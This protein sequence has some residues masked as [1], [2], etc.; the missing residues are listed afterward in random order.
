MSLSKL[1]LVMIF[2]IVVVD[3]GRAAV[4]TFS[5]SKAITE[6]SDIN[7]S[8]TLIAA[9][10][11]GGTDVSST[12]VNGVTFSPFALTGNPTTVGD[13]E[14]SET[15]TAAGLNAANVFGSSS[16]P[17]SVLSASYRSLL[18]TAIYSGIE[19]AMVLEFNNLTIGQSYLI[20]LCSNFSNTSFASS[21]GAKTIQGG[22]GNLV[23]MS[24][25][26]AIADGGTGTYAVGRFVADAAS[27]SIQ[28]NGGST[29]PILNAFQLRT[30]PDSLPG[31]FDGDNN[32]GGR[33]FLIWQRGTSPAPLSAADLADWRVNYGLEFDDPPFGQPLT[34]VPELS[35]LCLLSIAMLG[36]FAHRR[37][38]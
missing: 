16:P 7:I 6:D 32:V 17:Y 3:S 36:V 27:Q 28:I 12:T 1:V 29:L 22:G 5:P 21:P 30:L 14:L 23:T 20:Q 34:A 37:R 33:D 18:S 38:V 10:N 24:Q 4:V 8:G 35:S 19:E 15:S 13:Y 9:F 25:N 26:L 11:F 31:D 2:A